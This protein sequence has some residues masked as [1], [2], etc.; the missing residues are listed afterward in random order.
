MADLKE[1]LI[2]QYREQQFKYV[3][4]IIA[5]C[6][7]AIGFVASQTVGKQLKYIQ[8]PAGVGVGFWCLSIYCGIRFI[9][10]QISGIY[11]NVEY[12]RIPE[13]TS[14]SVGKQPRLYE[15]A[16]GEMERIIKNNGNRASVFFNWQERCFYFGI[17]SFIVWH[18][19]EMANVTPN[20]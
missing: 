7:A 12:L 11:T 4:Y 6:V 20:R 10:Y 9:Q 3:Y 16:M 18:I 13:G 14:D 1:E 2:K 5:L 17:A 8:I 15:F 19:L